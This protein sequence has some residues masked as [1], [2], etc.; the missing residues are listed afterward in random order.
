MKVIISLL[1]LAACCA[2]SSLQVAQA[3]S[4]TSSGA[5]IYGRVTRDADFFPS[6]MQPVVLSKHDSFMLNI[7]TREGRP[8]PESPS[9]Y[10]PYRKMD[11]YRMYDDDGSNIGTN[12]R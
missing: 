2:T 4:N 5:D 8:Q 6:G 3:A 9:A 7:A 12:N 11:P 1:L 10:G